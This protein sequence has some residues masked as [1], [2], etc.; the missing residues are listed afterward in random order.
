MSVDVID[1]E[2][3]TGFAA[4]DMAGAKGTARECVPESV[5]EYG[6]HPAGV[7]FTVGM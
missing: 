7:Y 4:T 5:C 1:I 6:P 3:T 2:V